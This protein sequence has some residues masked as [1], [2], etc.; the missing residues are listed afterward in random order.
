MLCCGWLCFILMLAVW[1]FGFSLF[2]CCCCNAS[3]CLSNCKSGR[4]FM[5]DLGIYCLKGILHSIFESQLNNIDSNKGVAE[6]TE[7]STRVS[8]PPSL[9]VEM[10]TKLLYG[11]L[12]L[13][14]IPRI[15][16]V[17]SIKLW[18]KTCC[19]DFEY[20]L[21]PILVDITSGL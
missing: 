6:I 14:G 5:R 9:N 18:T 12:F 15:K 20:F 7:I 10:R 21:D 19:F 2:R 11:P 4:T 17:R 16:R 3:L 1:S 8:R 13:F